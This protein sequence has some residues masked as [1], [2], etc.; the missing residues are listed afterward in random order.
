MFYDTRVQEKNEMNTERN[1]KIKTYIKLS[2]NK[3]IKKHSTIII[4]L[5][6]SKV[7]SVML[8]SNCKLYD[9]KGK[10]AKMYE[11]M[12][13]YVCVYVKGKK[14]MRERKRKRE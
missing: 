1:K 11:R 8:Y 2:G 4:V 9:F 10:N 12:C 5:S 7:F 14:R 6:W 3:K 13:I